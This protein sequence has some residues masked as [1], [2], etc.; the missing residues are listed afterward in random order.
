[1]T[2]ILPRQG[3]AGLRYFKLILSS[4]DKLQ[5][6]T[7][8]DN[9]RHTTFLGDIK[10]NLDF[11]LTVQHFQRSGTQTKDKYLY[12][13][14]EIYLP[15]KFGVSQ[16]NYSI[17]ADGTAH[18]HCPVQVE[19]NIPLSFPLVSPI[20]VKLPTYSGYQICARRNGFLFFKL[21]KQM[22]LLSLPPTAVYT[23]DFFSLF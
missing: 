23:G 4:P 5:L 11:L 16:T 21:G 20:I 14:R 18:L 22:L 6:Q 10:L 9:P 13:C 12:Y 8:F 15:P 7:L 19:D 3:R 17:P 1:M 2:T